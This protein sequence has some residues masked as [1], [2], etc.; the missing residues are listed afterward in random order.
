MTVKNPKNDVKNNKISN[1]ILQD[2][3]EIQHFDYS[4]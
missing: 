2:T 4:L 1:K 3:V